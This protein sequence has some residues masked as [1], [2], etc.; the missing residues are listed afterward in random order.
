MKILQ[1]NK[2]DLIRGDSRSCKILLQKSLADKSIIP[3]DL[4]EYS[5]IGFTAKANGTTVL[6]LS[7][8]NGITVPE[9][10]NG[11]IYLDIEPD[12]TKTAVWKIAEFDL[13]LTDT[14]GRVKTVMFGVVTL[15][16]DYTI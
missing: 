5:R 15:K 1:T 14:Y 4:S 13:Q 8:G 6:S 2:I 9:P 3:F 12:H 7:L 16:H 11:E 10:S